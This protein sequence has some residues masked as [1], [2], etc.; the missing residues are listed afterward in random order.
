MSK[1][2]CR[3]CKAIN[4]ETSWLCHNCRWTLPLTSYNFTDKVCTVEECR[5]FTLQRNIEILE[6]RN[7]ELEKQYWY[8]LKTVARLMKRVRQLERNIARLLNFCDKVRGHRDT[9]KERE[10]EILMRI[11]DLNT[12]EEIKKALGEYIRSEM[13]D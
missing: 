9:D 13:E 2:I 3:N 7:K 1:I 4:P 5:E 10:L 12:T 11:M 8:D 6:E